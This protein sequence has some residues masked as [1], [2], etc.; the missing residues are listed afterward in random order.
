MDAAVKR[1]TKFDMPK[2][3]RPD[4][5]HRLLFPTRRNASFFVKETLFDH[6]LCHRQCYRQRNFPTSI[7]VDTG[8]RPGNSNTETGWVSKRVVD[9]KTGNALNRNA[10]SIAK[11]QATVNANNGNTPSR[12]TLSKM[13][14]MAMLLQGQLCQSVL[15]LELLLQ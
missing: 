10:P 3:A 8:T 14:G 6:H 12:T 4:L 9:D 2:E 1:T 5:A 11:R 15:S 7:L 13:L